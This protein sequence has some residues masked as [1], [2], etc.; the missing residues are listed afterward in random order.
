MARKKSSAK[1]GK[2]KSKVKEKLS[3]IL[4]EDIEDLVEKKTEEAKIVT[5]QKAKEV[6]EYVKKNPLQAVTIAFLAGF[7]FGKLL[8]K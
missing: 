1:R 8:R 7:M 4:D 2:A 5:E 3:N 6:E